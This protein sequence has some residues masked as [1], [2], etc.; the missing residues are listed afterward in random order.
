[1]TE[2]KPETRQLNI[3]L[4]PDFH[5][6]IRLHCA[7]RDMSIKSF[8]VQA[9]ERELVR[10]AGKAYDADP[11]RPPMTSMHPQEAE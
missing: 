4:D 9:V 3:H 10:S 8:V 2:K 11:T 1:M 5:R 6:Q 7:Q